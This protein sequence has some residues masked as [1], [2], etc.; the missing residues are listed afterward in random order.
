M[1]ITAKEL[2]DKSGMLSKADKIDQLI[3][4]RDDLRFRLAHIEKSLDRI[5]Y[6]YQY[7]DRQSS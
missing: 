5:L 2:R 1:T 3:K 6:S 7:A 4:E